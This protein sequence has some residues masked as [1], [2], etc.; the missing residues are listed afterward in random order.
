MEP[1]SLRFLSF[2]ATKRAAS[3]QPARAARQQSHGASS[4]RHHPSGALGQR[5]ADT[6]RQPHPSPVLQESVDKAVAPALTGLLLPRRPAH[7]QPRRDD[8][9]ALRGRC[10]L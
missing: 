6:L 4:T 3:S 7:Q 9:E 10:Q 8:A 5:Y 2:L 1:W